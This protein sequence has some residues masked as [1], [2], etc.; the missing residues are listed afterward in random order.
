MTRRELLAAAGAACAVRLQARSNWDKTRL[1]VITDEVGNTVDESIA[2]AHQYGLSFLEIRDRV[3]P[4]NR[5]E[6]FTLNEAEIKA[7]ALR[8]N[9]EGLKVSFVNTSQMKFTWPG[10]EVARRRPEDDAARDRRLAMEKAQFDN[11]FETLN[12]AIRCAQWMGCDKVRVFT[13]N[14]VAEPQSQYQRIADAIGE[15]TK[16]AE[17]EKIYLCV[18][19]EGSQN[20][21]TAAELAAIAK[22]IP[23]KWVGVL[24]DPHN[25]Y[26][27]ELAYPDGYKLLPFNRLMNVQVKAYGIMPDSKEKED[28]KAIMTALADD[29][30]PG[31]V[32]LET[33]IYDGT[34]IAGAHVSIEE[35]I[36]ITREVGG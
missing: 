15:M 19:N 35:M 9:K 30:Y 3:L 34:L 4:G 6:Y 24:W 22:L 27:R 28:W 16:I 31:K 20:V 2:F 25:A 12:K 18:E 26:G 29:G 21:G 10:M 23:S 36:R 13:G 17:K 5:K 7:D 8:F 14:R 33:H 11:R 1:S 32:G